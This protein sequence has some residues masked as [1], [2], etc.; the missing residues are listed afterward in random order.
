[1]KEIIE[2]DVDYPLEEVLDE[3]SKQDLREMMRRGSRQSAKIKG[4]EE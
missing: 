1:M 3:T 4:N 2:T